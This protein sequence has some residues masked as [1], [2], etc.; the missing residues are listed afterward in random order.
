MGIPESSRR[1]LPE[2]VAK[3][4][5]TD[6]T[7]GQTLSLDGTADVRST[8]AIAVPSAFPFS[9]SIRLY[10]AETDQRGVFYQGDVTTAAEFISIY[11]FTQ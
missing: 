9:F 6:L 10:T 5:V 2:S 7:H 3:K 4:I 1:I 11:F 8:S